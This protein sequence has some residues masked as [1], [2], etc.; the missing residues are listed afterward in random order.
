MLAR[1]ASEA[2]F[3]K[4]HGEL[5]K[6]L[7][8]GEYKRDLPKDATPEQAAEWRKERGIPDNPDGYGAV[9][10]P[11]GVVL[12][13]NDKPVVAL[14]DKFFH[15]NNIAPDLRN[16]II[17]RHYEIQEALATERDER[18]ST[19]RTQADDALRAE[20]GA[21]Y[22][23][24][25]NAVQNFLDSYFPAEVANQIRAGR[26]HDGVKIGND[27]RILKVLAQVARELD[28]AATL[29]NPAGGTPGQTVGQRLDAIRAIR[30]NKPDEWQQ[31]RAAL[32]KEE[33]ELLE[34]QQRQQAR[35]K[36]A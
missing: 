6:R 21:D 16:R 23:A 29:V 19:F 11:G 2:D 12:G 3:G 35:G 34:I 28:P 9:S 20:W 10:L 7:H 24:N 18:D 13:D 32:E 17:G 14:Y 25:L 4:A 33:I 27:P 8:S 26:T 5:Y 36:A 30:V 1:Y 15:E 31:N 22:R